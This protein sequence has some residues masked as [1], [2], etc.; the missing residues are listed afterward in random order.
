MDSQDVVHLSRSIVG[1]RESEAVARVILADGYLGM[2]REVQ[3][4]EVE[5]ASFLGIP[6]TRIAC[7]SSGTAAL[8][9]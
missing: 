9:L 8:H 1:A 3:T 7:V 6:S 4:F 5:L 2:G